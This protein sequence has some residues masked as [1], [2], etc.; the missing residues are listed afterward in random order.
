M[1]AKVGTLTIAD[2]LKVRFQ[3]VAEYGRDTIQEVLRRDL[4]AHNALVGQMVSDLCEVTTDRQR[5]YGTSISGEMYE[6]DEFGRVP[7]KKELPGSTVGFPLKLYQYAIG[8][9]EKWFQV[10][11]PAE[12]AEQVNGSQRAHLKLL[13]DEVKKA[14]YLSANYTHQDFLIDYV[15]LAVKRLVNADSAP[16]PD[17]PNGEV[18]DGSTHDHYNANAG[19]TAALLQANTEDVI[20]HGHG[21]HPVIYINKANETAVRALTGFEPYIDPRVVYRASDTLARTLDLT[22]LDNRAIGIFEQAEVWVKPWAITGYAL[23]LDLAAPKPLA[24]RQRTNTALR[25]LRVVAENEAFPMLAQFMEAEF[26]IGCWQRTNGAVF[27]FVNA[28]YTDPTI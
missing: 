18:F 21:S 20:E 8:W 3:S 1:A 9:T 25:G 22:R 13:G 7:V 15:D 27:D 6:V 24:F 14:F 19:L 2:L 11:T 4:A 28:T 16:I 10:H 17:G 23:C 5:I 12:M 26:G